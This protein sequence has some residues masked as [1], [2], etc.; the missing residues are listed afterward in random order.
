MKEI[1]PKDIIFIILF[2]TAF[3]SVILAFQIVSFQILT[4]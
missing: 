1:T 4:E 2:F 3:L